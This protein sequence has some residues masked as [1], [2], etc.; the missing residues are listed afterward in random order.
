MECVE[1]MKPV[2]FRNWGIKVAKFRGGKGRGGVAI[3]F[4]ELDLTGFDRCFISLIVRGHIKSF[5]LGGTPQ[6]KGGGADGR[7]SIYFF[8]PLLNHPP[9]PFIM[10]TF[11]MRSRSMLLEFQ[12]VF[13]PFLVCFILKIPGYGKRKGTMNARL[14]FK[15]L[16]MRR[17]R[18][19]RRLLRKYRDAKKVD[20]HLYHDLYHKVKGNQFKNKRL[21]P[22]YTLKDQDFFSPILFWEEKNRCGTLMGNCEE[23]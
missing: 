13:M 6:G 22:I 14:P 15:V 8:M 3:C 11:S 18:V 4:P 23:E 2:A 12:K 19:L 21:V 9:H 7:S 10:H 5:C 1:N 16:W 17:Q 20:K